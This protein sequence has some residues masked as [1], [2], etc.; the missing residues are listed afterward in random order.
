MRTPVYDRKN[1]NGGAKLGGSP[2]YGF[3]TEPKWRT[4]K[5]PFAPKLV[6]RKNFD[7]KVPKRTDAVRSV[8]SD[9]S[10][11][12][13]AGEPEVSMFDGSSKNFGE[14]AAN[15]EV[16]KPDRCQGLRR[17][18][19]VWRNTKFCPLCEPKWR[20][21]NLPHGPKW[22]LGRNWPGGD[23]EV[24]P[25]WRICKIQTRLVFKTPENR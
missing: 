12:H 19:D 11:L 10:N 20:A 17:L 7:R 21:Q 16:S 1:R 5:P 8:R 13:A 25:D 14:L 3:L 22:S 2:N 6:H 23:P 24:E 15:L 4:E 18:D 9:S